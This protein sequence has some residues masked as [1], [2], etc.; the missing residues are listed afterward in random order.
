MKK[1]SK[2]KFF[3]WLLAFFIPIGFS[4]FAMIPSFSSNPQQAWISKYLVYL[5][6]ICLAIPFIYITMVS[7]IIQ[8]N[9][10][11]VFLRDFLCFLRYRPSVLLG[12]KGFTYFKASL[13]RLFNKGGYCFS[14]FLLESAGEPDLVT[15]ELEQYNSSITED[16]RQ[17]IFI[18]YERII[19]LDDPFE[20][21][22]WIEK[23]RNACQKAEKIKIQSTVHYVISKNRTMV[24]FIRAFVPRLSITLFKFSNEPLGKITLLTLGDLIP[25]NGSRFR[26]GLGIA[27]KSKTIYDIIFRLK[28]KILVSGNPHLRTIGPDD[29][30]STVLSIDPL[31]AT[32]RQILYDMEDIAIA[33]DFIEHVGLFGSTALQFGLQTSFQ[34][35]ERKYFGGDIDFIVVVDPSSDI[36]KVRKIIEKQLK[37]NRTDIEIEFSNKDNKFY[38]FRNKYHIDIQLH[39]TGDDYYYNN[40]KLLS[41]SIFCGHYHAIYSRRNLAIDKLI[42]ISRSPLLQ[43]ERINLFLNDRLGLLNFIKHCKSYEPNIDPRRVISITVNNFIW[44]LSGMWPS[45]ETECFSSNI[46]SSTNIFNTNDLQRIR[47]SNLT[48]PGATQ[49]KLLAETIHILEEIEKYLRIQHKQIY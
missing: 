12:N 46:I 25:H 39:T 45:T 30:T 11:I 9:F 49:Q 36:N 31:S 48:G 19:M 17:E 2:K 40:S 18:D 26:P 21:Q 32:T 24:R 35:D 34:E 13:F 8:N 38:E 1:N 29:N 4:A 6:L 37:I 28:N 42:K 41:Y 10:I 16:K 44:S 5:C 47:N 7:P 14:T 15:N 3:F 43:Q 20:Q 33:Y 23:F 27:F 22:K